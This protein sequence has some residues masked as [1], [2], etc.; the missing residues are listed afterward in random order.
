MEEGAHLTKVLPFQGT[1]VRVSTSGVRGKA[2]LLPGGTA[3]AGVG[4]RYHSKV[5]I[6]SLALSPSSSVVG[7][8]LQANVF[9]G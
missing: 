1:W 2:V 5:T 9:V 4:P 7:E 6:C 3:D 8:R